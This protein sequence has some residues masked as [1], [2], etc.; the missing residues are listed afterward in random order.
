MDDTFIDNL[1]DESGWKVFGTSMVVIMKVGA[2]ANNALFSINGG[3]V[4]K[5]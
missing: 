1:V 4:G 2:Y 5:P 3:G